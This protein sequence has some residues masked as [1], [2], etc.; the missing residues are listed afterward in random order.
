MTTLPYYLD[1]QYS[2]WQDLEDY[3]S[4]IHENYFVMLGYYDLFSS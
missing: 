2:D 3:K 1:R 4:K